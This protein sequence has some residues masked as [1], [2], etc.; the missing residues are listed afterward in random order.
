MNYVMFGGLIYELVVWLV[1]LLVDIILV[2]FDMVFFSDFGLVLVEVVV[3][4]VL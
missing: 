1:K 2:G 4:M 3:K